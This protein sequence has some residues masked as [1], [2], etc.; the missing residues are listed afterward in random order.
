MSE[1]IIKL[2]EKHK[3]YPKEHPLLTCLARNSFKDIS[4]DKWMEEL[5]LTYFDE[6]ISDEEMEEAPG[7]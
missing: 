5:D 2:K 7:K 6:F 4:K 1:F 3:S